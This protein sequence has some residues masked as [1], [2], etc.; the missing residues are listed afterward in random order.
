[1]DIIDRRLALAM[2]GAAASAPLFPA[3]LL[4]ADSFVMWRDPGCGCCL[5]WAKRME[6]AFGRR[7]PIVGA[8]DMAAIKRVR[9]VPADL[10]SCHT[11]LIHGYSI[12]GHVPPADIRRLIAARPAGVRGLAVPGMPVGSPGME[13]GDHRDPYKVIAFGPAGR[14]VF[15]IHGASR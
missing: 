7:L 10:H 1:M 3:R 5:A 8:S 2:L 9:G 12:E 4:A 15:A 6:A 13:H 11:A 14:S